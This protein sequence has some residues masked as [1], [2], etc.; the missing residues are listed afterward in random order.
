MKS[1]AV[2][3]KNT[4]HVYWKAVEAGAREGALEAAVEMVWKGSLKEDALRVW[5][6]N[7]L[8][9]RKAGSVNMEHAGGA[10][11]GWSKLVSGGYCN[12]R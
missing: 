6:R 4:T 11:S 1:I 12:S 2:I 7:I 3:P 9:G 5:M 8:L 10:R